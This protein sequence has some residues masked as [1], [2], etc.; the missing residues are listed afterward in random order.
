MWQ[1][2]RPLWYSL[3]P[4]LRT[5]D[6]KDDNVTTRTTNDPNWRRGESCVTTDVTTAQDSWR[7]KWRPKYDPDDPDDNGWLPRTIHVTTC[8]RPWK[9][10][11]RHLT[12]PSGDFIAEVESC[13][14]CRWGY[15][16][17]HRIESQ[18]HLIINNNLTYYIIFYFVGTGRAGGFF[19]NFTLHRFKTKNANTNFE[20]NIAR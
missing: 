2:W 13:L 7:P 6:E 16:D 4:W 1:H 18:V 17:T 5:S 20:Q 9:F 11:W 15:E 19:D 8:Q 10:S 3:S 14:S 12:T